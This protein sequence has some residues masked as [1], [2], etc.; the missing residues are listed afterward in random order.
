MKNGKTGIERLISAAKNS[1]DGLRA[2]LRSE[3]AFRQDCLLAAV[4]L[5]VA[6]AADV[7]KAERCTLVIPLF[8]LLIAETLNSAVEKCVD[9]VSPNF[10][11]LAKFAK[12]AGS[13][14]VFIALANIA[15]CWI[16]VFVF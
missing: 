16:V 2:T 12:D 9:L 3:A 13:A 8:V 10:H 1:L 11:P 15:V 5:C 6:L 4:L 14:A 7:S